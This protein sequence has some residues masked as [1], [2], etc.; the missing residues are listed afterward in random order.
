M[1]FHITRKS[2]AARLSK[3]RTASIICGVLFLTPLANVASAADAN[4]LA[5]PAVIDNPGMIDGFLKF[6]MYGPIGFAGLML[7]LVIL[8]LT[9]SKMNEARERVLTRMMYVGAGCFTIAVAANVFAPAGTYTQWLRVIPLDEGENQIFPKPIVKANG[10]RVDDNMSYL[11]KKDVTTIVD[12]SDAIEFVKN[13]IFTPRPA[14]DLHYYWAKIE[15]RDWAA[16]DLACSPKSEPVTSIP[17]MALCDQKT[18]G[19]VAAC[20]SGRK[21]GWPLD[22]PG[23][24]VCSGSA[25]WCTYRERTVTTLDLPKTL[26]KALPKAVPKTL[27]KAP[28]PTFY[29]CMADQTRGAQA[30][31]ESPIVPRPQPQK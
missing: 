24:S 21:D 12:V 29:I 3:S 8:A 17:G 10:Q 27:S 18:A 4:A 20:W 23:A 30:R 6:L 28:Q 14:A 22:V 2:P 15:V 26:S 25:D 19:N 13:G 1:A 11:V 16:R 7:I 9:T 31:E 5:R